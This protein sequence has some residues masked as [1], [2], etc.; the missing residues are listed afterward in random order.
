[1]ITSYT[2]CDISRHTTFGLPAQVARY[3]EYSTPEELIQL[4]SDPQ[5]AVRYYCIGG[6]SNVLFAGRYDGTVLHCVRDSITETDRTAGVV[7]LKVAAG[8]DWDRFVAFTVGQGMYGAENLSYIPGQ[9]GGAAVQNVGAYGVEVKD[10]IESVEVVDTTDFSRVTLMPD[11]LHYGY[12]DSVFKHQPGRYIV[13]DVNVR[14]SLDPHFTLDYGPLRELQGFQGL[15][16]AMVRERVIEIRKSK[17]PDPTEIGSAG[18]FFKN[19]VVSAE[20]YAALKARYSDMPGYLLADGRVKLAAGWLI[21]HAGLKGAVE[22]GAMVYPRQCLVIVNTGSA[23]AD[24]V[25][26]LM[27]HVQDVVRDAYNVSLSPEVNI[28]K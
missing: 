11:D 3:V 1:M 28:V 8:A 14:L 7:R 18:S 26:K 2:D 24:D 21:E 25:V 16:A 9:M 10:I 17:L 13:T 27:H 15:T 19:P 20:E 4:L 12:R 22:G 6:G 23:T 5:T